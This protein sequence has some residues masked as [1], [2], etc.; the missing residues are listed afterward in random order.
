MR[1]ILG[2]VFGAAVLL[3]AGTAFADPQW[4]EVVGVDGQ[5]QVRD[6]QG[7]VV[8]SV[9]VG[10]RLPPGGGIE[11]GETGRVVVR[12][13]D[14]GFAVLDRKSRLD[15]A[16]PRDNLGWLRQVTGWI[17]YALNRDPARK[18]AVEVRTT[19]ATIGVRGT[20]FLVV[21]VP[22]RDE[23]GMRKGQVDIE[24]PE[25][26]F[27]L[28]RASEKDEFD[29]FKKEGAAAI[30]REKEDFR[31]FNSATQAEFAEYTRAFTLGSD[32]QAVFDGKRVREQA[33][34]EETRRDMESAEAFAKSWLDQVRD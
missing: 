11:T 21:A 31:R 33:L 25:G 9:R 13:G 32:R 10:V 2:I 6:A 1:G 8:G 27:E 29:A 16:P 17:Y 20:R 3:S 5:A 34:S 14:K 15:V 23:V 18:Q 19:V 12:L 22:G 26:E 24:S 30:D 28:Y 7:K 4:P